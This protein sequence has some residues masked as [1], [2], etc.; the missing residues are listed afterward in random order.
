M[1]NALC[2]RCSK[3]P[4]TMMHA[5]LSCEDVQMVWTKFLGWM[6]K[7]IGAVCSFSYLLDMVKTKPHLLNIFAV[8]AWKLWNCRNKTKVGEAMIPIETKADS[9]WHTT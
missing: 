4:E 5:L 2:S 6:D 1:P 3:E 8:T 7:G 9:A